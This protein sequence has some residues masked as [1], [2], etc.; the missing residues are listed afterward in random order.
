MAPERTRSIVRGPEISKYNQTITLHSRM[1]HEMGALI[2]PVG[3]KSRLSAM[4][5]HDT[6]HAVPNQKHFY[7]L[8]RE[9]LVR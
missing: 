7:G 5:I 3:K 8:L 4:Y 9:G 1:Y 6:E 2:P